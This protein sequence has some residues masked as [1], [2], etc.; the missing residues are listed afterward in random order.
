M[1][2]RNVLSC[3]RTSVCI[4][5]GCKCSSPV[6][7][8]LCGAS[9]ESA[10][11]GAAEKTRCSWPGTSTATGAAH[12]PHNTE[13]QM[14]GTTLITKK[15]F[16][17]CYTANSMQKKALLIIFGLMSF[18]SLHQTKPE[19]VVVSYLVFI[20]QHSSSSQEYSDTEVPVLTS[21][22]LLCPANERV[23]FSEEPL[24]WPHQPTLYWGTWGLSLQCRDVIS[25]PGPASA[26][27][28]LPSWTCLEH[29]PREAPRRHPHQM[30]EPPQLAPFNAKELKEFLM[31]DWTS[32]H[33]SVSTS[34]P[35]KET[36][37]NHM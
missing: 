5:Q 19:A 32:P 28:P 26:L 23:H 8:E 21:R 18:F 4:V 7:A 24:P 13:Q 36:H 25:P 27:G 34:H 3:H 9:G 17:S 16:C 29:L 22:G 1:Q 15:I 12:L 33:P 10:G 31:D 6:P 35:R 20:K 37:F 14:E 11:S 30:P 2:K